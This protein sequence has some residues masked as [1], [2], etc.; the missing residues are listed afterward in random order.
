MKKG[1]QTPRSI[2]IFR[3][4]QLGDLLCTVPTF[5]ALRSYYP[6]AHIALV[7]LPWAATFVNRFSA[8]L[9]E[10]IA[11]PGWPGLPEQ[12]IQMRKIPGFLNKLQARRF[13]L[14]IQM[15][16][17]GHISNPLTLLFGARSTNG[18]MRAE[19]P[20]LELGQ[21]FPYPD[22][23]HEIRIFLKLLELIGVPAQG[24]QLEF[25]FSAIERADFEFFCQEHGLQPGAYICL[26][27]GARNLKRRWPPEKFAALGDRLAERGYQVVLTGTAPEGALTYEIA[28]RMQR[29]ALNL[30]GKTDLATMGLLVE[31]AR[32]LISNDTGVSHI[33]AALRTPS[34]VLFTVSEPQRWRPL[35]DYLH[36]IITSADQASP[37]RV[38]KEVD[39]LLFKERAYAP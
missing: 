1:L 34:I 18:W 15:Q 7:G 36:P 23:E 33:A 28:A 39:Q 27:P 6:Q 5:R 10:F 12:D 19:Q 26:H 17:D 2:V 31:N 20:P 3:A 29:P 11:F 35:D 25:P 22:G 30:T 37:D 8:Y 13:D 14:A 16:G 9:D 21:F 24:E 32:L 4:L 38:M